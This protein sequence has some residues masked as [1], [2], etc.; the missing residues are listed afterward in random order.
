M[1]FDVVVVG[2]GSAGAP[3]AALLSAD[4]TRRVLLVE[5]G[6]DYRS[7]KTPEAI[8]GPNFAMALGLGKYHW[9]EL[10][11]RLTDRQPAGLYLSG[12]GVGGSSAIN[13]QGAVRGLPVDFD[14]WALGGCA[15]WSWREVLPTFVRLEHDYD[16]GDRPFHGTGGPVPV[17]RDQEGAWGAVSSALRDAAAAA[18]HPWTDDLNSPESTGVSPI[19]WNR[20]GGARV[21]TNDAYLEPA[22]GRANLTVRAQAQV[23]RLLFSG[24]R[25]TGL[26]LDSAEDQL[27]VEAGEVILCA[28]AIH[29]PAILMR[30]GV[31]PAEELRR[32]G[33]EVVADSPSVGRGLQDHPMAWLTFPLAPAAT[34]SSPNVLPSNCVL[35]FSL[36]G[37]GGRPNEME[38][39]PLDRAPMDASVGGF[40]IA[41]MR[42]S[43]AGTVRLVS[44]EPHVEPAVEFNMLSEAEDVSRLREAVRYAVTLARSSALAGVMGAGLRLPSGQDPGELDDAALG[45]W[46]KEN[47]VPHFHAAGT[48]HM[49]GPGDAEAVV[50]TEG[51]V[52]GVEGLRVVDASIMPD[53]PTAPTHLT[54]VMIAEHIYGRSFADR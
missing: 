44:P 38:I 33:I 4:T 53:L 26:Q 18:G 41:L 37:D 7:A 45:L 15:G 12:R 49:G 13:G 19:P 52:L 42:P 3:L 50:D 43:S 54:T 14:R 5:A 1:F 40:M 32:L 34:A 35:R 51:R 8:R 23:G 30:S 9:P 36:D 16:F 2:A 46:L 28:G 6:E 20:V 17:S 21:S 47:C 27:A 31:G 48:C 24:T 22:R 39:M 11:A 29:S 10:Y 25:L